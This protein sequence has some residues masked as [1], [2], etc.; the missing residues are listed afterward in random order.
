MSNNPFRRSTGNVETNSGSFGEYEGFPRETSAA[1]DTQTLPATQGYTAVNSNLSAQAPEIAQKPTIL[2]AVP[3]VSQHLTD[4]HQPGPTT[5]A[6]LPAPVPAQRN[7]GYVNALPEAGSNSHFQ[8][9]AP[10]V[11]RNA[12]HAHV[13]SFSHVRKESLPHPRPTYVRAL[14]SQMP[15]SEAPRMTP[16][17][18]YAE[19]LRRERAED[20][21]T[22]WFQ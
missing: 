8:H 16:G 4:P 22:A 3:E 20:V 7:G 2:S 14:S 18:A 11:I 19:A 6:L 17:E 9:Q 12:R 13:P 1:P 21:K 10:E 15:E 5:L